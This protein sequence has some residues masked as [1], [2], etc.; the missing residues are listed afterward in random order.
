MDKNEAIAKLREMYKP[1]GTVTT[2]IYH[3]SRS[4]MM[5]CIGVLSNGTEG[6]EDISY[7]VAAATGS[8][9]SRNHGGVILNGCGMDMGFALACNLSHVL[10][11]DGFDCI[12]YTLEGRDLYRTSEPRDRSLMCPSND[13]SNGLRAWGRHK[14][15]R[16]ALR[17]RWVN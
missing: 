5:R 13:H 16:R 9:V 2:T 12:Q 1:G 15:S 6:P 3:V 4:G 14:D 7:L 8:K 17:H 11:R 10:F